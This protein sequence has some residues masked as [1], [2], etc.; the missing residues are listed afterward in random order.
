VNTAVYQKKPPPE[1]LESPPP[2]SEGTR[3]G[4]VFVFPFNDMFGWNF[5][6]GMARDEDL[7]QVT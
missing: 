4:Y 3:T 6:S 2:V 7:N 5:R 1:D